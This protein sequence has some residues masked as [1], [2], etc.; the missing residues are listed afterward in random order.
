M[1][2]I[3][4]ILSITLISAFATGAAADEPIVQPGLYGVL[5]NFDGNDVKSEV[6][7]EGDQV[8][9]LQDLIINTLEEMD[10]CAVDFVERSQ[11]NAKWEM[12][13]TEY[14]AKR[15]TAGTITWT[16][17]SFSG[18]AKSKMGEIDAEYA[19]KAERIGNCE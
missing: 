14:Q 15:T 19:F 17:T 1:K 11:S 8:A 4:T 6:C 18:G 12:A 9:T 7:L 5:I 3:F 16:P 10:N 13:C 2:A